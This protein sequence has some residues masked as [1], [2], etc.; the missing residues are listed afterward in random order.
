M[1]RRWKEEKG[2]YRG[3]IF[4]RN[5]SELKEIRQ[6]GGRVIA[7]DEPTSTSGYLLPMGALMEAGLRVRPLKETSTS[8]SLAADEVGYLFAGDEETVFFWVLRGKAAA[9]AIHEGKFERF[10]KGHPEQ[11]TAIFTTASVPRHVVCHRRDLDSQ[12]TTAVREVLLGM[13]QTASGREALRK[14]QRTTKFDEIPGGADAALHPVR[15]SM[16]L[17]ESLGIPQ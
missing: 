16:R 17:L 8:V 7:L 14:F 13:E 3:V 6:L 5:D 15:R 10:R 2:E 4:V 9:G 1:L 11:C 12:R